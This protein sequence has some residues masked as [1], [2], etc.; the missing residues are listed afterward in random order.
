MEE[1][2]QKYI[3]FI[4]DMDFA[5]YK[6]DLCFTAV[7]YYLHNHPNNNAIEIDERFKMK[8]ALQDAIKIYPEISNITWDEF[9]DN[10][11]MYNAFN[12]SF[13]KAFCKWKE[14][15]WFGMTA[16]M[17]KDVDSMMYVCDCDLPY[18]GAYNL[19]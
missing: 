7:Y 15:G 6:I 2:I 19:L 3:D 16:T 4:L 11:T 13:F 1:E 17:I 10:K 18:K 5:D 12:T 14:R 8:E 9:I